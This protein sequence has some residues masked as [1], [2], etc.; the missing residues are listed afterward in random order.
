MKPILSKSQNPLQT[1]FTEKC[2]PSNGAVLITEAIAEATEQKKE[3]Y[4]VTLDARKAF[5]VVWQES[6]LI[7]MSEQGITG[8]I[9][10]A[11]VNMYDRVTSKVCI[12]GQLSREIKETFGIRQGAESSTEV[13]KCRTNIL[14]NELCQQPDGLHIG[15]IN[16]AAPTCADDVCLLS[17]SYVGT[18]TLINIAEAGQPQTEV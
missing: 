16:I 8:R 1:G 2:S 18:Q 10:M 6:A 7:A 13:F 14:L 4:I 9:W 3:L 12:N 5:D 11:F 15:Y 17:A